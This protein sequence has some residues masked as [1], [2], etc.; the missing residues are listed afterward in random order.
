MR[1]AEVRPEHG[2]DE[3]KDGYDRRIGREDVE[4][5]IRSYNSGLSCTKISI[6]SGISFSIIYEIISDECSDMPRV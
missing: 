2:G 4:Y 6:L 5:V 3:S 1:D